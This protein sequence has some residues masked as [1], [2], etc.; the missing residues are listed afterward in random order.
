MKKFQLFLNGDVID[1]Q[2]SSVEDEFLRGFE[3]VAGEGH[4]TSDGFCGEI[5][6]PVEM[7]GRGAKHID[8]RE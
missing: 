8:I 6:V 1:F 3:K 5:D 2:R 7:D 4:V